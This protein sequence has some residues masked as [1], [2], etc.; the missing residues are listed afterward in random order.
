MAKRASEASSGSKLVPVPLEQ[1]V[2]LGAELGIP[3]AMAEKNVFRI[4]LRRPRLAK[5]V[6]E[7]LGSLLFGADLDDRLREL[8]IMRV[9]WVTG[10]DYEWTQHWIVAQRCGCTPEELVAV[11]DWYASPGFGEAERAVLQATDETLETGAISEET[12]N[13]CDALLGGEACLELILT[14]GAWRAVSQYL[15]S[16]GVPLEEDLSSWPPDGR[17]PETP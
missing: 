17:G 5:G 16:V 10:S 3:E 6:S 15:R 9:G 8:A 2:K 13:R 12:W 4:L 1:A 14:I 11:R 7:L